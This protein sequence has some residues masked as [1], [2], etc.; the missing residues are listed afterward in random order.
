MRLK[1]RKWGDAKCMDYDPNSADKDKRSECPRLALQH[2]LKVLWFR[3]PFWVEGVYRHQKVWELGVRVNG[4][5]VRGPKSL[6]PQLGLW[7]PLG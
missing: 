5:L 6:A 7:R 3:L 1:N 4:K 2:K